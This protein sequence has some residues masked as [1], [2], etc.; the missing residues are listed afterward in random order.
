M[1]REVCSTAN[2]E[3]ILRYLC[4]RMGLAFCTLEAPPKYYIY[5]SIVALSL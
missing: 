4:S 5:N 2:N 3:E 1:N